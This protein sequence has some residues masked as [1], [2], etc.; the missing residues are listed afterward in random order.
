MYN[1][2]LCV[3]SCI[4]KVL[5]LQRGSVFLCHRVVRVSVAW[6][7]MAAVQYYDFLLHIHCRDSIVKGWYSQLHK[8]RH[9]CIACTITVPLPLPL[10]KFQ[11]CFC[12][13]CFAYSRWSGVALIDSAVLRQKCKQ[14]VELKNDKKR[15]KN[16]KKNGK[17]SCKRWIKNVIWPGGSSPGRL[18][19]ITVIVFLLQT[20]YMF[21]RTRSL[22]NA[23]LR[24][25]PIIIKFM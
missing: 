13:R 1:T 9:C 4:Y 8:S 14:N 25:R 17:N 12:Y 6:H 22:S 21:K 5:M 24:N 11:Y 7:W 3:I 16:L 18:R 20:R 19:D 10:H 2:P 23:S 15:K